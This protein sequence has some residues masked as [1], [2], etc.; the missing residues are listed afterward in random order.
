[1]LQYRIGQGTDIHT[2]T[3]NRDF[4]LGGIKIPYNKGF[5]AHSDGDV[6][7]HAII[8]ALFGSLSL[9]DIGTHFPDNN[10]LYKDADSTV[11]LKKTADIIRSCGWEINNIDTTIHA[12]AP[13]LQP[14]I[15]QIKNNLAEILQIRPQQISVKAKTNEGVDAVGLNL[16]VS[17]ECSVLIFNNDSK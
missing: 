3:E 5:K 15:A 13:K 4:I 17:A 16:A 12:Q 2:L 8:D 9:D 10:P 11:L 7:I 14:Y 6:L 1:M